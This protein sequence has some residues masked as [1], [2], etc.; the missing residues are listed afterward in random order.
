MKN[1]L[2]ASSLVM[3]GLLMVSVPLFAHHGNASYGNAKQLT[4]KGTV[5]EWVW[6][7]P[8]TLLK[9]EVKDDAGQ[10]VNWVVEW[11]APSSL[12]NFGINKKTFKPGDEVTVFIITPD[13]GAPVGRIQRVM[14]ANGTWLRG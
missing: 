5:T 13:N 2:A 9:I 3:I 11:S 7:N 6:L 10:V 1:S 8:H 14:V 12:I 4:V